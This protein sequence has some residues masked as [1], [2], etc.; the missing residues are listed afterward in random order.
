MSLFHDEFL[1]SEGTTRVAGIQLG[2]VRMGVYLQFPLKPTLWACWRQPRR[3]FRFWRFGI[4]I[5]KP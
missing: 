2:R 3:H 5:D 4:T 1:K